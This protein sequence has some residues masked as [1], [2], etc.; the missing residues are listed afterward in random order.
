MKNRIIR[1][2][3]T[4]TLIPRLIVGLVFL[5]EGIQKFITPETVGAGRFAKLGFSHPEFWAPFTGSFEIVC[6]ILILLG[7][8]T[9]VA[10][11]PLSV[12]MVVAFITTK[13]SMLME[14]GF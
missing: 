9:R 6:G 1:T 2:T 7:L 11:V 4:N 14:K 3:P 10:C 8:F 12:I 13:Y 5:S